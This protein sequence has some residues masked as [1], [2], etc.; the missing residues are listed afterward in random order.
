MKYEEPV[1][2]T[3]EFSMIDIVRTS[4]VDGSGDG[5]DTMELFG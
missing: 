5:D 1:M 4:P 2:E 3:M